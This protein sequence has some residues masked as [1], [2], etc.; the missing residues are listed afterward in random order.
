MEKFVGSEFEGII[1]SVTKFGVFVLL[2]QYDVDGLIRL[3]SL[4][5][6]YFEFDEENLCLVG[7]K[8]GKTYNLGDSLKVLVA[9]VDSQDGRID[10]V[11]SEEGRYI[12]P[13]PRV[14][15]NKGAKPRK[16]SARKKSGDKKT[17]STKAGISLK[18]NR[19]GLRKTRVSKS[20]RKGKN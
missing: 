12:P 19:R 2:R 14:E 6:D 11:L 7:K 3:E 17:K 5:D 8:T 13:T 16:K 20:R 9:Q 15:D 1:S 18:A 4:G 10:F